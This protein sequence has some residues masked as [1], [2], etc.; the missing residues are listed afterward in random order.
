MPSEAHQP[1][2]IALVSLSIRDFRGIDS[3]DLDFLGPDG[4]PNRLAVIG[5]P[6]GC[7]KT[8][9][10]E[11]ARIV[12]SANSSETGA[13]G[14]QAIRRGAKDLFIEGIFVASTGTRFELR[15]RVSSSETKASRPDSIQCSYFS[16]DR[17]SGFVGG[18]DVSMNQT[19]Q[20]RVNPV[21]KRLRSLKQRRINPE[22]N[23]LRNLKQ[24]LINAAAV[25]RFSQ[26]WQKDPG[27]YSRW[28]NSIASA[29]NEFDPSRQAS[30]EVG[31]TDPDGSAN[32]SFDLYY[33]QP[34]QPRLEVDLLSSGQLELFSFIAELT[35][36]KEREGIVLIDE[37]ELHLDP[38][39]HRPFIR[40]LMRLQPRA[41]FIVTTLSPD[42]FD[43]AYSHERHFLVPEDDPRARIWKQK[44]PTVQGA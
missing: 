5:G 12:S 28:V 31:L 21:P 22:A 16:S 38:Q 27:L 17:S 2:S 40:S 26:T 41:Q 9:V 23:R 37:P 13:V 1:P 32:G 24:R 20:P 35:F 42:F 6:N 14:K 7:G 4:L 33:I 3:L 36:N 8:S 44:N 30:F 34:G 29:W 19:Q 10:L 43:A 39:W 18:I 15:T 11:A 25:E